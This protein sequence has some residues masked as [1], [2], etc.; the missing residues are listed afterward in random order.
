MV[1]ALII[2]AG[3]NI[4]G[5]KIEQVMGA[6][7]KGA[8][9]LVISSLAATGYSAIAAGISLRIQPFMEFSVPVSKTENRAALMIRGR[10]VPKTYARI[11][12]CGCR[13][14]KSKIPT[15]LIFVVGRNRLLVTAL[16]DKH[17]RV[18]GMS[19]G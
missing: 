15:I 8:V 14:R 16:F 18:A 12:R 4:P 13:R 9:H 11:V 1:Y 19:Y 2:V 3:K 17:N 6:R 7:G 5:G 10:G